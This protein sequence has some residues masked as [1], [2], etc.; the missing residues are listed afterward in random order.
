[1]SKQFEQYIV[2]LCQ[3][4]P[5]WVYE[6]AIS[7]FC[8]GCVIL[9][10]IYGLNRGWRKILWLF[11]VEYVFLFYCSTVFFRTYFE[12]RGHNFNLFWSYKAIQAGR[13]ELLPE[14]IMNVVV[15]VPI[16]ILLGSLI[17]VRG[18]WLITLA[19]GLGISVSIEAMQ[20]FLKRGFAELDDAMH[21]ILGG[22]IGYGII[23]LT[24]KI[25]KV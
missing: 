16:G 4:I 11:L 22:I 8:I 9:L 18:S 21:N 1:M 24:R 5:G 10:A 7:V 17:R 15:F 20:Y 13:V 23:S 6:G 2:M 25:I 12:E 14:N 3:V 19:V